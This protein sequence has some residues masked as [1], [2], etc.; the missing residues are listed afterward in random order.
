MEDLA[1][2]S[3]LWM[4]G[5]NSAAAPRKK[6][7]DHIGPYVE[8]GMIMVNAMPKEMVKRATWKER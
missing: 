3:R 4:P 5:S 2:E 6:G 1:R 8:C 7:R